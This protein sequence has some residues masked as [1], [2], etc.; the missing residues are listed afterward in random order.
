VT[1]D[2]VVKSC[3]EKF[4][5]DSKP[6]TRKQK[7]KATPVRGRG[8]LQS[9]ETSRPPHF[10]DNKITDGGEVGLTRQQRFTPH[11]Y[12]WFSF[13]LETESTQGTSAV[14]RIR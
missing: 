6:C 8:G 12:S 3:P 13:L 14:G 10:L 1:D 5:S 7:S 11:E 9:C 4:H 2:T